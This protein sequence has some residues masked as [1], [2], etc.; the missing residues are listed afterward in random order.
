MLPRSLPLPLHTHTHTVNVQNEKEEANNTKAL[1]RFEFLE[2]IVRMGMLKYVQN[3]DEKS[4]PRAVDRLCREH[5]ALFSIDSNVFRRDKMYKES[6]HDVIAKRMAAVEAMFNAICG[7]DRRIDIGEWCKTLELCDVLTLEYTEKQALVDFV[8]SNPLIIDE[9]SRSAAQQKRDRPTC[10]TFS[11]YLE[12]LCRVANSK[13]CGGEVA[14][15]SGSSGEGGAEGTAN[16]DAGTNVEADATPAA[17]GAGE[18]SGR[19]EATEETKEEKKEGGGGE[20]GEGK[21]D[22][23]GVDEFGEVEART[24]LE[25]AVEILID[26]LID[27]FSRLSK[28][29]VKEI[30]TL[31]TMADA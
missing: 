25:D 8:L 19:G 28:E 18:G 9:H 5:L 23:E 10:L 14:G 17:A 2:A 24:T 11:Q 31:N 26:E 15:V 3:G 7:A 20:G 4:I 16:V 1:N 27:S 13:F 22:E 12:A 21:E 29:D 6:I 30:A